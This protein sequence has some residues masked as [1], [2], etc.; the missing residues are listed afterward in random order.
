MI[1]GDQRE[2]V[3]SNIAS[4][5]AAEAFH[6]K[7]EVSDPVLT[8]EQAKAIVQNYLSHRKTAAYKCKAWTARRIANC[9]TRLLNRD[10]QIV[11][12]EKMEAITGGAILTSN[13]F[14]PL[15]NTVVRRLTQTLGKKRINIISQ[16]TNFAMEGTIGF[17]MNYADT[18]PLSDE[19]HYMMRQ[20]PEILEELVSKDEFILIYPE[21]EMW[22]NYRKPRPLMRGAYHFAAR[23]NCPVVS[24]FVEMQDEEAMDTPRFHKIRYVLHILDILLPDPRKSVRENSI[25]LCQQDYELKKAAYEQAYGKEL[26]YDFEPGD[27]AGWTG[28]HE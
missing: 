13:H 18:I 1:I 24:C 9:S 3:I 26:R 19:P 12:L 22:F 28:A 4:A 8:P 10:T 14:S 6:N 25:L 11:G 2:K 23:L 15:D 20:L 21:K 7:V 17:L 27:I 5:A 16:Q